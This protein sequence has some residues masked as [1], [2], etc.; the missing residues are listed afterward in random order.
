MARAR[1]A[2]GYKCVS[3]ALAHPM[4]VADRLAADVSDGVAVKS[5]LRLAARQIVGV[6]VAGL[7]ASHSGRIYGVAVAQAVW[8]IDGRIPLHT[9]SADVR[10]A[11]LS[12]KTVYGICNVKVWVCLDDLSV[13]RRQTQKA[14]QGQVKTEEQGWQSNKLR[15]LRSESR[16]WCAYR[17]TPGSQRSD[18]EIY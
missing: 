18:Y 6:S 16:F 2:F 14:V 17:R 12:I 1:S 13:C 3:N 7:K 9:L 4:Y 11:S 10:Y 5:S 8:H 15:R